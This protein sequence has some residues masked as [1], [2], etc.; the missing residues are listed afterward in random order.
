[1]PRADG[2][3]QRR[4]PEQLHPGGG[5]GGGERAAALPRRVR[6]PQNSRRGGRLLPAGPA[7]PPPGRGTPEGAPPQPRPAARP[8]PARRAAGPARRVGSVAGR[9]GVHGGSWRQAVRR[10]SPP[11][12]QTRASTRRLT[13]PVPARTRTR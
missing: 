8:P 13:R 5:R 6:G 3:G 2:V 1:D 12:T 11:A 9:S 7:P 10:G 4:A